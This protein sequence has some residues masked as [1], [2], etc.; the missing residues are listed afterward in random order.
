MILRLVVSMRWLS[1]LKRIGIIAGQTISDMARMASPT[2]FGLSDMLIRQILSAEA[3][4]GGGRG[5]E[6]HKFVL[7]A[8]EAAAPL[9][10]KLAEVTAGRDLADDAL[11]ASGVNKLISGYVEIMNAFG[12]LPHGESKRSNP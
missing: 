6:K 11:F 4:F 8:V 5:E 9:V 3:A 10:L 2:L 7:G 12:I 1:L